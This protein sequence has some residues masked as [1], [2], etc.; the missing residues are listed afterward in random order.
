MW[1]PN[2]ICFL[3]SASHWAKNLKIVHDY[4]KDWNQHFLKLFL[5][6]PQRATPSEN[7]Q[8]TLILAFEAN[9][10]AFPNIALFW[11]FRP[12]WS[13]ETPWKE[14][15]PSSTLQFTRWYTHT[16][17]SWW[18]KIYRFCNSNSIRI[19]I[20]TVENHFDFSAVKPFWLL[21]S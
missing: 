17:N 16:R 11:D 2:Q 20:N 19:L 10:A 15:E 18:P 5:F 9:S 14:K 8:K 3:K 7:F 4:L 6:I 21:L 13:A 1:C 12:L